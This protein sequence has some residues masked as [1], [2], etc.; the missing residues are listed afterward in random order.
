MFKTCR[1]QIA[2]NK[3]RR[4]SSRRTESN[5]NHINPLFKFNH[6]PPL[7]ESHTFIFF[8]MYQRLSN[9]SF[10]CQAMVVMKCL[11]FLLGKKGLCGLYILV[12]WKVWWFWVE[13]WMIIEFESV[14]WLSLNVIIVKFWHVF[15]FVC[16]VKMNSFV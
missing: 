5:F 11:V 15:T 9:P 14:E 2:R 10:V 3:I 7:A 1:F 16:F 8:E 6:C 13:M 12:Y 4:I